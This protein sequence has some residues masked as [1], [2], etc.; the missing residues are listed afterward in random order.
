MTDR[1][2]EQGRAPIA[3]NRLGGMYHLGTL[4][5][6]G[7]R[8]ADPLLLALAG[9]LTFWLRFGH[10]DV[11]PL[12]LQT[13]ARA[14]LLSLVLLG[15]SGLY[16]SW[17]GRSRLSEVGLLALLWAMV[18]GACL[19]YALLL[20]IPAP[21][22]RSWWG[23]WWFATLALTGGLRVGVRWFAGWV[24]AHGIDVRRVAIVGAGPE[25]A[26]I[27]AALGRDPSAGFEIVGWFDARSDSRFLRSVP[28]LG[29]VHSI[30][31]QVEQCRLDQV[32]IALPM[33]AQAE[34]QDVITALGD[35]T[36]EVRYVPDLMGMQLLNH[37]VEEIAGLPVI[38]L[39]MGP[40][41]GTGRLLKAIEDRVL[42][43]LILLLIAPLL[44][45]IAIA[46]KL[47]SPGPVLFRQER[48]GRDGRIIEVW[49]FRSMRV[50]QEHAGQVTQATRDDARITRLGQFLRKTS[51]DELPQFFNVLQGTMSIVGPRP[52]AV[53]HNRHYMRLVSNYMQRHRVKPGITGWAQ[54][55]GLR[56]ETD[57]VEKM[58]ARVEYDLYYLQ[59]WSLQFDLRIIVLT[60]FTGFVGR[61]AY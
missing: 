22:S 15:M 34:I 45:L 2:M 44:A 58:E 57:T 9:V 54:V 50:H 52:H 37:S 20:K 26:R 55:N 38:N 36:V 14:V 56:G 23:G 59:N 6:W 10:A 18:L 46:I 53:A 30:A 25:S 17:R 35:S 43:V 31:M 51:L 47:D 32:W 5:T 42:A 12:Y 1:A 28:Y 61:N 60:A 11:S 3:G 21:L 29:G 4:I 40:L 13:I 27:L 24:R 16:R 7:M 49:K 39:R 33:S 8:V 19:A 48:H 41:D